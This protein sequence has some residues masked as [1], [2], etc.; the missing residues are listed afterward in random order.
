MLAN[1]QYKVEKIGVVKETAPNIH[2]ITIKFYYNEDIVYAFGRYDDYLGYVDNL[3][4]VEFRYEIIEG[5][6]SQ[7]VNN[8]T[9]IHQVVTLDREDGLK[10]YTNDLQNIG[11]NIVFGDIKDGELVERAIVF[12]QDSQRESSDKASW[13]KL[14]VIDNRRRVTYLR[15]F[16]PDNEG[17]HLIGKWIKCRM[18]KTKY[19]FNTTDVMLHEELTIDA[20]PNVVIAE[21]FVQSHI[22][23]DLILSDY[24]NKY[25]LLQKIKDYSYE[26]GEEQGMLLVR[27]AMELSVIEETKNM[28]DQ[29]DIE[30]LKR[31]AV[32]SKS[33][34]IHTPS[35]TTY[36]RNLQN[37]IAIAGHTISK[38]RK[39][40]CCLDEGKDAP[41]V[42]LEREYYL[43]V[44]N[45]AKT[46][47]RINGPEEIKSTLEGMKRK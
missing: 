18:R 36:S 45:L 24:C 34:T 9:V 4:T 46:L 23:S 8:L 19:G 47:V 26:Y 38:D 40:I 5:H 29:I 1:G 33:Y 15:M 39:L 25:N 2:L 6:E 44:N 10:L 43:H 42:I 27:L 37:I 31:L 17:E 28:S 3:V 7:V 22:A 30:L 21:R 13:V 11:S 14:K 20:N 41:E 32:T 12:C 16:D 35:T